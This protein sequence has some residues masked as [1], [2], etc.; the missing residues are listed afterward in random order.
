MR[1]FAPPRQLDFI[2]VISDIV[3]ITSWQQSQMQTESRRWFLNLG[4]NLDRAASYS[5]PADLGRLLM[6]SLKKQAN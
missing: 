2:T 1:K 3:I 5:Q 6:A 4:L